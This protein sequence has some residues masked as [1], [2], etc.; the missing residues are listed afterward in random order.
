MADKEGTFLDDKESLRALCVQLGPVAYR[1]YEGMG[2]LS[3]ESGFPSRKMILYTLRRGQ[4]EDIS[5]LTLG[6]ME[7][8]RIGGPTLEISDEH[9]REVV[10]VK[11]VK[12]RGRDIFIHVPQSFVLKWKGKQLSDGRVQFAPQ[13]AI[14][15]KTRSREHLQV[16]GH[17]YLVTWNLFRDRFP[18]V[19]IRY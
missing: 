7:M 18:R 14:L 17:T 12:W 9:G 8:T 1:E 5:I 2:A 6:D 19:P 16:E 3:L 10:G 15:Y 4:P 11:P 13:Y